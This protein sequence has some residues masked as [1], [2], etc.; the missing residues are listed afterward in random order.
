MPNE[1][2]TLGKGAIADHAIELS[3]HT[4]SVS[5]VA[6][7]IA[8]ALIRSRTVLTLPFTI[9]V[10]HVA[11][12]ILAMAIQGENVGQSLAAFWTRIRF[13]RLGFPRVRTSLHAGC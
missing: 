10:A 3:W 1:T 9:G 12:G 4:A 11:T 8:L 7:Q 2:A 5:R 6:Y 13:V